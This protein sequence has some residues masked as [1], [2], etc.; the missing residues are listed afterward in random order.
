MASNGSDLLGLR[1]LLTLRHLELDPLI[2]VEAAVAVRRDG[3]GT[4]RYDLAVYHKMLSMMIST[5]SDVRRRRSARR[6]TNNGQR[7]SPCR[8]R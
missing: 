6:S 7:N 8:R 2:F 1:T 3:A 5:L 4:Q